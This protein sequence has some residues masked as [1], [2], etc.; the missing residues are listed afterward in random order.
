MK[1]TRIFMIAAF[2]LAVGSAFTSAK[3]HSYNPTGWYPN[4]SSCSSAATNQPNCSTS[5]TGSNCSI[6]VG[7]SNFGTVYDS[8]TDCQHNPPI[9]ILKQP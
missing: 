4:G 8:Q 7:L 9:G 5:N 1:K 6:T 2:V 3:V